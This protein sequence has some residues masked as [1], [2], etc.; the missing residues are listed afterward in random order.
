MS[1][2]KEGIQADQQAVPQQPFKLEGHEENGIVPSQATTSGPV[3]THTASGHY[4][5]YKKTALPSTA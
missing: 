3:N 4:F 5:T 2:H 1:T